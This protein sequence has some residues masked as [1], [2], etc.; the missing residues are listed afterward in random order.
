[1]SVI[2]DTRITGHED[3]DQRIDT[4]HDA[5]RAFYDHWDPQLFALRRAKE[6]ALAAYD[7]LGG[8][9]QDAAARAAIESQHDARID[10]LVTRGTEHHSSFDRLLSFFAE[11]A[12]DSEGQCLH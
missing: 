1:M 6:E 8:H 2:F 4:V 5:M 11:V 9:M 3:V 10:D 12:C 7:S